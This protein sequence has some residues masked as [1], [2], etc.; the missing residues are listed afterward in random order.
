MMNVYCGSLFSFSVCGKTNRILVGL[1]AQEHIVEI[2]FERK[3][4]AWQ[5]ASDFIEHSE[6]VSFPRVL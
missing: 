6:F 5:T 3:F 4:A 1:L 2:I